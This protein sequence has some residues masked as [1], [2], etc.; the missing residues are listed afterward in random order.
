MVVFRGPSSGQLVREL[1]D[2]CP[3]PRQVP[4][5]GGVHPDLFDALFTLPQVH[6]LLDLVGPGQCVDTE[7]VPVQ[8]LAGSGR[9]TRAC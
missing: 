9:L 1:Q 8:Q 3:K 5:M 4:S 7:E 2:M 6:P